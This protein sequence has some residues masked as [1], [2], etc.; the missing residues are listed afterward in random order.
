M[1]NFYKRKKV[2][3]TATKRKY[4]YKIG[5]ALSGGGAKG[6]AHIGAIKAFEEAGLTFDF[7]SGTSAGSI[8]GALF[9]AGFSSESMEQ[10]GKTIKESDIK[11][12][13]ILLVPSKS[14]NIASLMR[15]FA[16]D[17]SFKDLKIPFACCATDISSGE[18]VILDKGQLAPAVAASC[19]APVFFDGIVLD[20]VRLVDGGLVNNIPAD[21]VRRMGAEIV[22]SVSLNETG[23]EGTDSK[24]ILNVLWATFAITMRSTSYKGILNSDFL[25][26]PN[27]KGFKATKLAGIDEMIKAGYDAAKDQIP[28]VLEI[29]GEKIKKTKVKKPKK[30]KRIK[31]KKDEAENIIKQDNII[32]DKEIFESGEN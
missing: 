31:D 20:G 6:F 21:V 7:I 13:K 28:F 26:R 12:S 24:N 3:A 19:S 17:I 11:N 23:S 22:V 1:W 16:G 30:E 5:L 32:E 9:A 14:E 4:K 25:I 8:V 10:L 18:E 2:A 27:L 15:K 29:L